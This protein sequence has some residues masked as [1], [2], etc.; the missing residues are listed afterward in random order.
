MTQNVVRSDSYLARLVKIRVNW[1]EYSRISKKKFGKWHKD[2]DKIR[3][4]RVSF[5]F[6]H[7]IESIKNNKEEDEKV[8][9]N[10]VRES[11]NIREKT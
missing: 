5:P 9:K 3:K 4:E 10:I 11:R 2:R 1:Y 8:R 7:N 6:G